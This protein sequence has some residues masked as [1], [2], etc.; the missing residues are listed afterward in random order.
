MAQRPRVPAASQ[1]QSA[2]AFRQFVPGLLVRERFVTEAGPGRR[3]ALWDLLIGPGMRG[4]PATLPGG[5]VLE[6]RA[7]TGDIVIG[8]KK[9]SLRPGASL[10]V[11]EGVSLRFV[12]ARRDLGFALRAT[13]VIG[14]PG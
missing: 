14:G 2:P 5:A 8:D 12:N 13:I 4:A 3:V 7:G 9:R 10:A 6:V 11:P 1:S